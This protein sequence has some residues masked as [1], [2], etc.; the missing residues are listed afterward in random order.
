MYIDRQT[1][2]HIYMYACGWDRAFKPNF[3]PSL[4]LSHTVLDKSSLENHLIHK[5][6]PKGKFHKDVNNEFKAVFDSINSL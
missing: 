3:I 5:M 2:I 6:L 1:Y 4:W